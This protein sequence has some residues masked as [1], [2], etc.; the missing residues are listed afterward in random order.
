MDTAAQILGLVIAV[1]F[2]IALGLV[3]YGRLQGRLAEMARDIVEL[4]AEDAHLHKRISDKGDE[5]DKVREGQIRLEE[6][7]KFIRELL[8]RH[9]AKHHDEGG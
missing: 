8:E 6:G 5:W 9:M 4:K 1:A 3:G 2:P 7:Q